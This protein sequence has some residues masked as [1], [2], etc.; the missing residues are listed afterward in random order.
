MSFGLAVAVDPALALLVA[1][2]V[3]GEVVVEDGVEVLLEVDPLGEAVRR[4]EHP[5]LVSPELLH[6]RFALGG[7]ERAGDGGD[8]HAFELLPEFVRHVLGGGD[9]AAEDDGI[10]AVLNQPGDEPDRLLELGVRLAV[11]G[12]RLAGHLQEPAVLALALVL[13][14][15]VA[16]GRDVVA[17]LGVVLHQV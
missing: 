8:L 1:G 14:A 17:L 16:T 10:E 9:E 6:P 2:G 4:H 11:Q 7:R 15:G 5:L 12:L 3:P 13:L